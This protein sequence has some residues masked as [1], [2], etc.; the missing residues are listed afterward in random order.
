LALST[1]TK[2]QKYLLQAFHDV[3]EN[4]VSDSTTQLLIGALSFNIK[5]VE[6]LT[7][8][9][10]DNQRTVLDNLREQQQAAL[11]MLRS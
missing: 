5:E 9:F 7:H 3:Y 10:P 2:S 1:L 8:Q 4:D 6:G 11:D